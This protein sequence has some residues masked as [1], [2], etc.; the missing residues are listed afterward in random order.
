MA[1]DEDRKI[2]VEQ[3][4]FLNAYLPVDH[5]QIYLW[6]VA[7]DE[8]GQ[9]IVNCPSC[10]VKRFET[11]P[12]EIGCHTW[13]QVADIVA[14]QCGSA[15]SSCQ[16]ERFPGGQSRGVACD[17]LQEH[18]LPGF[19]QEM[20]AIVGCRPVHTKSQARASF[21]HLADGSYTRCQ[22]HVR[23]GTVRNAGVRLSQSADFLR[24]RMH[25]VGVP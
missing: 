23:A 16:P 3:L 19:V 10:Q 11:I 4:L 2:N 9:G 6:W 24:S 22:S 15:A 12:D 20:G 25:H 21:P 1:F 18:G 8:R 7:K 17:A 13:C 14:S 5:A